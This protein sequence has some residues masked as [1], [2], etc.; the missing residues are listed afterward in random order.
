MTTSRVF[1]V[2]VF[3]RGLWRVLGALW[4]D[5]PIDLI[6]VYYVN[7]EHG[8]ARVREDS[9]AMMRLDDQFIKR[10]KEALRSTT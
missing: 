5:G 1:D 4:S 3:N 2:V 6:E 9:L 8:E 10:I 7:P